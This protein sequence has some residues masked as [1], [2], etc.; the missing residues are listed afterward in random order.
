MQ[1]IVWLVYMQLCITTIGFLIEPIDL[2]RLYI[3][4]MQYVCVYVC[5]LCALAVR[6]TLGQYLLAAFPTVFGTLKQPIDD[7]SPNN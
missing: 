2:G 7:R 1:Q 3:S 5:V 6:L 4:T